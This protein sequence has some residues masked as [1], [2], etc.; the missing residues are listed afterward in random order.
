MQQVNVFVR[1]LPSLYRLGAE[2][3]YAYLPGEEVYEDVYENAEDILHSGGTFIYLRHCVEEHAELLVPLVER[4]GLRPTILFLDNTGDY[5]RHWKVWSLRLKDRKLQQTGILYL[6]G[7]RIVIAEGS[8]ATADSEGI[9]FADVSFG[10]D[11]TE[12]CRDTLF[13]WDGQLRFRVHAG[14]VFMREAQ[15]RYELDGY[16]RLTER[17]LPVVC[18]TDSPRWDTSKQGDDAIWAQANLGWESG[19]TETFTFPP[20]TVV[21]IAELPPV[22]MENLSFRFAQGTE[23]YYLAPYGNG[24]FLAD[25]DVK[26]GDIGR[27]RIRRNTRMVISVVEEGYLGDSGLSAEVSMLQIYAPLFAAGIELETNAPV[28][29]LPIDNDMGEQAV[30]RLRNEKLRSGSRPAYHSNICLNT[31]RFQMCISER[32]VLWLNLHGQERDI[33][34]IALCHVRGELAQA[35]TADSFFVVLDGQNQGLFDVP[36]TISA[37]R[38]ARAVQAGYPEEECGRLLKFYPS[39]RI[40]LSERMFSQAVENAQCTCTEELKQAC[41]HFQVSVGGENY[42]FLPEEWVVNGT[43]LVVKKGTAS[44]VAEWIDDVGAWSFRPEQTQTVKSFLKEVGEKAQG[45]AWEEAFREAVWE[46]SMVIS[47]SK[48]SGGQTRLLILQAG[49]NTAILGSI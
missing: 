16:D 45:T 42:S 22:C 14:E 34:G 11:R 23:E 32:E 26:M 17:Y 38:L 29:I 10:R 47:V 12:P 1:V 35:V 20:D 24:S 8:D 28:P 44:S 33:P 13:A 31:D 5:A 27:C 19:Q 15:I 43:I 2:A 41:H 4:F 25:A 3:V 36:Y 7:F 46:G 30:E 40:L 49:K 48:E 18:R 39:D 6:Y 37:D 21:S 9:R